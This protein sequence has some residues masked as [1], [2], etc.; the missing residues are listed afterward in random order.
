MAMSDKLLTD[1]RTGETIQ[2]VKATEAM[3]D[4]DI[5][6]VGLWQIVPEGRDRY[7]LEGDDLVQFL[8]LS[9][10]YMVCAWCEARENAS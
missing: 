2:F 8:R 9:L 6:G 1:R 7:G 10:L 5:D 4:A 3:Y